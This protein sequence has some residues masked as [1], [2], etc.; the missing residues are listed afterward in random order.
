MNRF[1]AGE[2][3]SMSATPW[4]ASVLPSAGAVSALH[5]R[6]KLWLVEQLLVVSL[7]MPRAWKL[8]SSSA[9]SEPRLSVPHPPGASQSQG[10]TTAVENLT[11]DAQQP[12]AAAATGN[13]KGRFVVPG[14]DFG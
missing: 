2:C 8:P 9:T 5:L 14:R 12:K 1:T 3:L 10:G 7:S 6:M 11:A 4:M 13:G